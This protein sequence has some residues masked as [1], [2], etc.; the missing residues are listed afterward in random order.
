MEQ[1]SVIARC[2]DVSASIILVALILSMRVAA[3]DPGDPAITPDGRTIIV[4]YVAEDGARGEPN[5]TVFTLDR[6]GKTKARIPVIDVAN[7]P[8][9]GGEAARAKLY[10]DTHP[11]EMSRLDPT[12]GADD[13]THQTYEGLTVDLSETGT[14]TVRPKGQRTIRRSNSGWRTKPTAAVAARMKKEADQGGNPCFNGAR[15]GPVWV[16][17]KRRAAVVFIRYHGNDSCWEPD[18]DFVVVTW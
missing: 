5:L 4:P 18:S 17:M 2:R 11:I 7:G 16:D 1:R 12:D 6:A 3:A 9:P 10:A 13:S 8:V 15:I 14:L